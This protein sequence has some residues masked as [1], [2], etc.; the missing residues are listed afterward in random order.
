MGGVRSVYRTAAI[1]QL[2]LLLLE[3]GYFSSV[4]CAAAAQEGILMRKPCLSRQD[5]IMSPSP[6]TAADGFSSC[7]CVWA[8]RE[9]AR[10][11][12]EIET[13]TLSSL[14]HWFLEMSP[15][16]TVEARQRSG[17]DK[18]GKQRKKINKYNH[19]CPQ[20]KGTDVSGPK[21][22]RQNTARFRPRS[23]IT[24]RRFV[25]GDRLVRSGLVWSES[26]SLRAEQEV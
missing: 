18:A 8:E 11:E 26:A 22:Q 9:R 17:C 3:M 7:V 13:H 25:S 10:E 15:V 16:Q 4:K 2:V 1:F 14:L 6:L 12:K 20:K 21:R 19:S 23:Q 5:S 24:S